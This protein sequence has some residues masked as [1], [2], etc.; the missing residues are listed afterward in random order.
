[1]KLDTRIGANRVL[2]VDDVSDTGSTEAFA[3]MGGITRTTEVNVV[4]GPSVKQSDEDIA[5]T[6][7]RESRVV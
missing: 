1:M 4:D 5:G 7:R 6:V 2:R 3:K